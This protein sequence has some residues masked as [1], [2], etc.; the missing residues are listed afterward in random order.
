MPKTLDFRVASWNIT[1]YDIIYNPGGFRTWVSQERSTPIII[2]GHWR[3]DETHN[4]TSNRFQRQPVCNCSL[5]GG[6]QT[7]WEEHIF[8]ALLLGGA[9][10]SRPPSLLGPMRTGRILRLPLR[11]FLS[12]IS[13]CSWDGGLRASATTHTECCLNVPDAAQGVCAPARVACPVFPPLRPAPRCRR[14][15]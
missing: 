6:G 2:F 7:L 3:Y 9:F 13:S 11:V 4:L 1:S 12:G 8:L 14:G 5:Y 15:Q 10:S